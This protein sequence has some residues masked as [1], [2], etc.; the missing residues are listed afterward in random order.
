LSRSFTRFFGSNTRK[1]PGQFG[2]VVLHHAARDAF[3]VSQVDGGAGRASRAESDPTELQPGGGGGRALA[4][5]FEGE[6]LGLLIGI[7]FHD[8]DTVHHRSDRADQ[9]VADARAQ[10]RRKIEGF[11]G[12]GTRHG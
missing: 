9:V 4:N 10:Q 6:N 7:V 3:G 5:Q 8:L 12:D 11:E 2:L 1:L